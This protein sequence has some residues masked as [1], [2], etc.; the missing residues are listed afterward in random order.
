MSLLINLWQATLFQNF[1]LLIHARRSFP[2]IL[3]LEYK[4]QYPHRNFSTESSALFTFLVPFFLEQHYFATKILIKKDTSSAVIK[5]KN[6]SSIMSNNDNK[7]DS[8][9]DNSDSNGLKIN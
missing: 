9:N 6:D 3:V 1:C 2:T 5:K 4:K 8:S 7:N